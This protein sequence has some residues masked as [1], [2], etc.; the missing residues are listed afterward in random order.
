[1]IINIKEIIKKKNA[2]SISGVET[3]M[4]DYVN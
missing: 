2:C 1:M 3:T 4:A